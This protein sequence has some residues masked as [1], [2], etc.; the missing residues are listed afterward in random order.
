M[1]HLDPIDD[2]MGADLNEKIKEMPQDFKEKAVAK[3]KK[4]N[5]TKIKF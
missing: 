1:L 3:S 2:P 4:A 5:T